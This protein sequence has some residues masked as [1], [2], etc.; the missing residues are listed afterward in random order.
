MDNVIVNGDNVTYK[1]TETVTK[2]I[3][4][5]SVSSRIA[6]LQK[7]LDYLKELEAAI[8]LAEKI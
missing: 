4:K 7:E 2:S 5:L 3:S 6:Q 8:A 1:E